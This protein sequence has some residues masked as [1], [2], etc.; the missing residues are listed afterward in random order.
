MILPSANAWSSNLLDYLTTLANVH[1]HNGLANWGPNHATKHTVELLNQSGSTPLLHH[2]PHGP[3][4]WITGEMPDAEFHFLTHVRPDHIFMFTTM[5]ELSV[6]QSTTPALI[7]STHDDRFLPLLLCSWG[8]FL[9]GTG[10]A[11]KYQLWQYLQKQ[12]YYELFKVKSPSIHWEATPK[13]NTQPNSPCAETN[14]CQHPA[15]CQ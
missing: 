13:K 3:E 11:L 8:V 15:W 5:A 14:T 4:S 9:C 10:E 6:F 2:T 12:L 1:S 7:L